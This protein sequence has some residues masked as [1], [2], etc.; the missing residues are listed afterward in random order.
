M[1]G[2][3]PAHAQ[4]LADRL[5]LDFTDPDLLVEALVHSSYVN[6]HPEDTGASN[7]R[8]EFLGDAVLSL[9][10]SQ[11]LWQRHPR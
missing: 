7:E 1:P 4:E 11:E 10:I 2:A 6:E 5:E 3:A 8:L 9:I